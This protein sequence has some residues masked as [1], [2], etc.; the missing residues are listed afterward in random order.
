LREQVTKKTALGTKALD[1]IKKLQ[2]KNVAA[3]VS[4]LQRTGFATEDL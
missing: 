2:A 4:Q 1:E 3:E